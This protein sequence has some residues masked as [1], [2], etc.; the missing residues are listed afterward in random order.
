M[1]DDA[2]PE[3]PEIADAAD[4]SELPAGFEEREDTVTTT[5]ALN[6]RSTPDGQADN[7]VTS[8]PAG[9][10]LSRV[11]EDPVSGWSAVLVPGEDRILYCATR[12]LEVP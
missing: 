3:D 6:I 7:K 1:Q 11:G 9:T 8:V 4:G 2:D 12:Y 5:A 10:E